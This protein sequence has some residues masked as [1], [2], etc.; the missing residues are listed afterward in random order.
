[1]IIY[2]PTD[3]IFLKVGGATIAI[4]PLTH[5]QKTLLLSLTRVTKGQV[6]SDI[7]ERSFRVLQQAIRS[8]EGLPE[9]KYPDGQ[10]VELK[11]ENEILTDESVEIVL[12]FLGTTK[13]Q[14]VSTSLL[15]GK[16]E[17]LTD[18]MVFE[19]DEKKT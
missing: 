17:D 5:R 12:Q 15:L 11:W 4:A 7:G 3:R 2:R 8:V 14:V 18:G 13:S 9:M 6:V 19:S 10:P 16:F 1:M